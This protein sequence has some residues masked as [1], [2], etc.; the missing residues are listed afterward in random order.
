MSVPGS[1]LLK[2]A[3]RLIK[4]QTAVHHRWKSNGE[5]SAGIL[6]P[7]YYPGDT[8]KANI[9]PTPRTLLEKLGLDLN[10]DYITVYSQAVLQVKDLQR[11]RAPDMLDFGR[12][13]YNVELNT[14][15]DI[16]DGWA[17]SVCCKIGPVP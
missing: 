15:W 1:N 13:R 12:D 7:T 5:N 2:M 16:Q 6:T 14:P 9:Q 10:A 17:G 8:I 3:N 11:G 4:Q